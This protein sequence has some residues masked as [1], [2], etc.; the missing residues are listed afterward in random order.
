MVGGR[1]A[2]VLDAVDR[3]RLEEFLRRRGIGRVR[4]LAQHGFGYVDL[5]LAEQ[6]DHVR[7][8]GIALGIR[9]EKS[10]RA[11]ALAGIGHGLGDERGDAGAEQ[12]RRRDVLDQADEGF[13]HVAV[14]HHQR[15]RQAEDLEAFDHGGRAGAGVGGIDQFDVP[16]GHARELCR[17]VGRAQVDAREAQLHLLVGEHLLR[18]FHADFAARVGRRHHADLVKVVFLHVLGDRLGEVQV[19]RAH[20]EGVAVG[21]RHYVGRSNQK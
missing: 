4:H 10:L 3:C 7:L 18:A 13:A 19:R 1:E 12:P 16:P 2:L 9:I 17:G 21:G 5:G 11:A 14:A 6:V 20:L 15:L 8:L